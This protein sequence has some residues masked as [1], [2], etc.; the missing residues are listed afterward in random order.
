MSDI[1]SIASKVDA[2]RT[3]H[4]DRDR[5]MLDVQ[6]VRRGNLSQ[7]APDLFSDEWPRPVIA[8]MIDTTARDFANALAPLPSFNCS[9][10]SML[11]DRAKA[12]ADKRTKIANHYVESSR[13]SVQMFTGADQWWSYGMLVLRAMPDFSCGNPYIKVEDAI[14]AYPTWNG[15]GETVEFARIYLRSWRELVAEY[16]Q[17]EQRLQRWRG[18]VDP[19][20]FIEVCRWEDEGQ[21]LVF[22][23]QMGSL[24]LEQ[25][26]NPLGECL[27]HAVRRPGLDDEIRG[28]LD[29]AIWIQIARNRLQMLTLEGVDKAVRAPLVVPPDVADVPVGVDAILRTSNPG[30]VQRARLDVPPQ[31]FSAV[32]QLRQEQL[33]GSSSPEARSGS[34]DASVITGQGVQQLMGGFN[35]HISGAQIVFVDA[36]K[37]VLAKCFR[38]DEKYFGGK[39]KTVHGQQAGVPYTITYKPTKDIAGDHTVDVH[40]GFASGLDPNRALVFLLQAEGAGL[41]SKDFTRRALPVGLNAVEEAQQLMI[42]ALRQ[43]SVQAVAGYVQSIPQLAAAGQDPTEAVFRTAQIIDGLEKG[44]TIEAVIMQAFA[45]KQPPAQANPG[46]PSQPGSDSPAGGAPQGFNSATG[47]PS[48][49]TP[50]E[51]SAGPGARPAL[52]QFLAGVSSS[53]APQLAARI[54]RQVPAV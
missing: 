23:P 10:S 37:C 53:G 19:Q 26:A 9:A 22:L 3:R 27:V 25:T 18:A 38:I 16:P 8:N 6:T 29:D 40:Y 42:E 44:K 12:F 11:S 54:N 33:V 49:L 41:I 20:G 14:G 17:A 5:R 24:V 7:L 43:S 45:P 21:S 39:S 46:S 35:S 34:I 47:V 31:A 52:A 36:M 2:L 30:G 13:L 4:A 32:D 28:A 51:E 1:A 48:Q 15:K 50:G